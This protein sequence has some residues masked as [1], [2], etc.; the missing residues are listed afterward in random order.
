VLLPVYNRINLDISHGRGSYIY[1]RSGRRYL[2]F[3]TGV[4]VNSLGH[5]HPEMVSAVRRQSE[6]LWHVS[7][8]FVIEEAEELAKMLTERTFADYVF[9]CNSGTEAVE[10]L[11]KM[12]RKY[13]DATGNPDK[14]RIITFTG[15]FHGR[16][17]AALWAGKRDPYMQAGFGPP[18]EG[19]DNVE[20]NNVDAVRAAVTD[21]TAAILIEPVQGDGGVRKATP[22]FLRALRKLADERGLLLCFDEVQCGA[23]RTG[24]LYA[25]EQ[26]GV[27]PDILAG[28]KGMGGGIPLGACMASAKAAVGMTVG[29]H[30]TTYGGNPLATAV[31]Q[32]VLR[33]LCAPGF[34]LHVREVGE[35]LAKRLEELRL[36]FPGEVEEIRGTGLLLGIKLRR[37]VKETCRRLAEFGLLAAPA[38]DGVVRLLP[39]LNVAREEADE[40]VSCL[41]AMFRDNA[42]RDAAADGK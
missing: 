23:G 32:V 22:E 9:F 34:L 35:Y 19:F 7:N 5:C 3:A 16:T 39:P 6:K 11:I 18:V 28:A 29:T 31:G 20:F 27:V 33:N 4:A 26:Y 13:H 1:S 24:T 25:Y 10:C 40:A 12:A 36:R 41:E 37:D 15:A 21:E 14:Y 8:L 42:K 38:A 30:G 17:L 2:D